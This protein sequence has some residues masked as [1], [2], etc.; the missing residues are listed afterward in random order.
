MEYRALFQA[1][2][3]VLL[4]Y[5]PSFRYR[6]SAILFECFANGKPCIVS[7]IEAFRAF[8]PHFRYQAFYRDR[9]DLASRLDGLLSSKCQGLPRP[10]RDLDGLA[11][12]SLRFMRFTPGRAPP[13]SLIA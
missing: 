5:P 7:D 2:G 10:Y 4:H 12:P 8:A 13:G 11:A 9:H 1:C 6:V 3:C